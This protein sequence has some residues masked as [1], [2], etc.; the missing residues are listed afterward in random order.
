M[1]CCARFFQVKQDMEESRRVIVNGS[2]YNY[3]NSSKYL[4]LGY[5]GFWWWYFLFELL[6]AKVSHETS[7]IHF[8]T[9]VNG[10]SILS[11]CKSLSHTFF[12]ILLSCLS[13]L[14]NIGAG[15][16]LGKMSSQLAGTLVQVFFCKVFVEFTFG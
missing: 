4:F 8:F 1:Y 9:K 10:V 12:G 14:D 2:I 3:E 5:I 11:E 16:L 13:E 7:F 15:L 6:N